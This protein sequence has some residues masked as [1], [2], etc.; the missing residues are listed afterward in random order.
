MKQPKFP[1]KFKYGETVY[2]ANG[3]NS[4]GEMTITFIDRCSG[5][6]ITYENNITFNT[7]AESLADGKAEMVH[8]PEEP[9]TR[10][11]LVIKVNCTELDKALETAKELEAT[12]LRIKGLMAQ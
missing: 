4:S 12:L 2:T 8:A 5:E 7:L 9:E 3:Q 11:T 10:D 6:V 1:F